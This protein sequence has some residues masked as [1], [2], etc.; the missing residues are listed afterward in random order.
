MMRNRKNAKS[1]SGLVSTAHDLSVKNDEFSPLL[2]PEGLLLGLS[3]D[4]VDSGLR[5]ADLAGNFSLG[6]T[7]VEAVAEELGPVHEPN[8]STLIGRVNS[9]LLEKTNKVLVMSIGQRIRQ[10]RKKRGLSQPALAN[11]AGVSQGTI[12]QLETNPTQQSKHLVAIARA[13]DVSVDWLEKGTGP[14]ERPKKTAIVPDESDQF[15]AIRKVVFRISAGVAGFAVDFLDD[16]EGAP[17]FFQKTWFEARGYSPDDLYAI[18]VRGASMEPSLNDGDTV[19]V[20]AEAKDPVDGEVFAANYDGELVIKRL[21]RDAGDWWL[22]SDSRD[23]RRYPRK[24]CD[25][26]TFIIGRIV[27]KQSERI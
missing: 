21:V 8:I 20:N 1:G 12:S 22:C 15:I 11:R 14:I 16:G 17:L 6:H 26:N 27:H 3:Q 5:S 18:K 19:V 2:V 13:L 24:R 25:E 23:D 7:C 10:L 9:Y 4:V